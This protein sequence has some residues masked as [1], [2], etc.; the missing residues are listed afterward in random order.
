MGIC[1]RTEALSEQLVTV[2]RVLSQKVSTLMADVIQNFT[3]NSEE[4]LVT[5]GVMGR[6][7]KQ[8]S[9][10]LPSATLWCQTIKNENLFCHKE[11]RENDSIREGI[12]VKQKC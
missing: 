10:N 5:H 8:Y 9:G 4:T 6:L 2:A 1:S 12:T 3:K 11:T 7:E